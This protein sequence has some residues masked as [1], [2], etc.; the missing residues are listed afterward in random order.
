MRDRWRQLL[1]RF[2]RDR[3]GVAAVEFALILPF[4]L[5]LYLG[6]IEVSSLYTADR[7]VTTIAGTVGDLVARTN[8]ALSTAV[9]TDYF[10]AAKRIMQPY[11]L[12]GLEQ[13]VSVVSVADNGTATVTWS[14]GSTPESTPRAVGTTYPLALGSQM[15][16]L[17]RDGFLVVTEVEY[18]YKPVYGVII[19]TTITLKRT[20]YFLPRY[21]VE[22]TIS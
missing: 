15:S 16:A 12:T 9:L 2:R 17:A 5:L 13:V 14:R 21:G 20:E 22:V 10:A 11:S 7:R 19:E 18:P 8:G 1:R 6:T 4:L 3:R